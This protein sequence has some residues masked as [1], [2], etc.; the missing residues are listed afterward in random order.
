M[1]N[2]PPAR[3]SISEVDSD[4]LQ[5]RSL[6]P[7]LSR[8]IIATTADRDPELQKRAAQVTAEHAK[9]GLFSVTVYAWQDIE[10]VLRLNPALASEFYQQLPSPASAIKE[11]SAIVAAEVASVATVNIP[12]SHAE[13]DQAVERL[14]QGSPEVAIVLLE[15]IQ[16]ERWDVLKPREKYRLLANLGLSHHAQGENDKATPLLLQAEQQQPN[17]EA[18]K[19]FGALGHLLAG[20]SLQAYEKAEA[21]W[22]VDPYL[23][24]A[25]AV[26][27]RTAPPELTYENLV[28]EIPE[29]V[30]REPDVARA[31][32][33]RAAQEGKFKE[34]EAVL[35]AVGDTESPPMAFSLG[36]AILYQEISRARLSGMR[37]L[38]ADQDRVIEAR[39]LLASAITAMTGSNAEEL[40]LAWY[41]RGQANLLLEDEQAAYADFERA[42]ES[43]P[44]D[45]D[46]GAAYASMALERGESA[47]ALQVAEKMFASDQRPRTRLLLALALEQEGG[48]DYLLKEERVL[49]EGLP[50]LIEA[51]SELRL[52]YI[53]TFIGVLAAR[54]SLDSQEVEGLTSSAAGSFEAAVIRASAELRMGAR[55][56]ASTSIE[57]VLNSIENVEN[58]Q[59]KRQAA[60]I[61]EELDRFAEALNVWLQLY[62]PGVADSEVRHVLRCA[63]DSDNDE[64]VLRIAAELRAGGAFVSEIIALE[65]D[66]LVR[67]NELGEARKVL[68]EYLAVEPQDSRA[69]M[70]LLNLAV[71]FDW[72]DITREY[73]ADLPSAF[74][75]NSPE[76]GFHIAAVYG[77]LGQS[78]KATQYAYELTRRFPDSPDSHRAL[79]TAVFGPRAG[80][81]D[82][83]KPTSIEVGCAVRFT[84]K[85]SGESRWIVIEDGS[86][87]QSSRGEYGPA[88]PLSL[89]MIGKS[90]GEEFSLPGSALV[91]RKG[92]VEE[93]QNRIVFRANEAMQLWSQRFPD[94]WLL[95]ALTV[96]EDEEAGTGQFLQEL[97]EIHRR[98]QEGP[99]AAEQLYKEKKLPL[100]ALATVASKE[101]PVVVDHLIHG[102]PPMVHCIEGTTEQFRRGA[103]A[104]DRAEAVVVDAVALSTL[105]LLRDHLPLAALPFRCIVTTGTVSEFRRLVDSSFDD[106][107][108]QGFLGF[109]G[110]RL[111]LTE[112]DRDLEHKRQEAMHVFVEQVEGS[113]E[114][115]GGRALASI[116]PSFRAKL[117]DL[118]GTATAETLAVASVRRVP[119][120][121][122]DFLTGL[123][124]TKELGTVQVWTQAVCLK[125][126]EMGRMSREAF[127]T[128]TV[129]LCQW[130]YRFTSI[131]PATIVAASLRSDWRPDE[132][133][134]R[135]VLAR[136]EEEWGFPNTLGFTMTT[137]TELW[138]ASPLEE[139]ATLVTLRICD[140]LLKKPYGRKILEAVGQNLESAFGVNV[141][142]ARSAKLALAACLES[143]KISGVILT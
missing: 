65:V 64:L 129:M 42:H 25:Q 38:A 138:K 108:L 91:E 95:E 21:A 100:P 15:K 123:I 128:I 9:L 75:V 56:S 93:V 47:T 131:A 139:Q 76:F 59:W 107:R 110:E 127:D 18:A 89:S 85:A 1:R 101:I 106:P 114:I 126:N 88:H 6:Q 102:S 41:N 77:K 30:R 90:P 8:F 122:D 78:N 62:V 74:A 136:L 113:C 82:L 26:R 87:P 143:A 135:S 117:R 35:R 115:V 13:I 11:F 46:F 23:P 40:P 45:S 111:V 69:R 121:T 12:G 4:I 49:R 99:R 73:S 79:I 50:Q 60:L 29:P 142:R 7:E 86:E 119:I 83:S 72:S 125:M 5:A 19:A 31:L 81:L 68:V 20:D 28:G 63:N 141:L 98:L 61:L 140:Y 27:I 24:V 51:D 48:A 118:M 103:A 54:Q 120:W 55:D 109:D 97:I 112:L 70:R 92:V 104:L 137:I 43:V 2:A 130:G 66:T 58:G 105:K 57:A 32:Y 116:E 10:E 124:G 53:V 39:S 22:K 80:T 17:D 67:Y 36:T 52:Q 37:M 34:A 94:T 44:T 133:P 33:L 96:P 16:R 134:L 71:V 14:K 132:E 3:L 84:E